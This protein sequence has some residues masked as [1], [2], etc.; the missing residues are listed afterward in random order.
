MTQSRL[1]QPRLHFVASPSESGQGALAEMIER[2]GQTPV[3]DAEVVVAIGGD[4]FMLRTLHRLKRLDLPVYGMKTG[5]VGFL[6]NRYEAENLPERLASAELVSL[7]PLR[8]RAETESGETSEALAINEVSLLRQTNQAAHIRISVN[9]SVKV[10][11]LVCDG[12]LVATAAGSTAYNFSVRG[13]ILPLGT[14]ALALT[15]ISPF[16]PRRWRG[17][18]LPGN[19]RITFDI[20]DPLKRS[21]SATADAFEVRNVVRV[22]VYEERDVSLHML[23]DEEH[24]LEERI[25]NEQFL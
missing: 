4:G 19:A 14:D 2:Y 15:P 10:E 16:R 13:P 5:N 11:A 24:S 21:V 1:S 9:D 17:A 3:E 18:V 23:F 25:L 20:L 7:H 12:V 6:M 22:E 8:M